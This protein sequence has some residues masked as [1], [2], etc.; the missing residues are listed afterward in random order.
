MGKKYIASEE[1]WKSQV[2]ESPTLGSGWREPY[3]ALHISP[4]NLQKLKMRFSP[5]NLDL[6][7]FPQVI[8]STLVEKSQ[9]LSGLKS[10]SQSY[11]GSLKMPPRVLLSSW[12]TPGCVTSYGNTDDTR[13][14]KSTIFSCHLHV[15]PSRSSLLVTLETN[16]CL[17]EDLR[18]ATCP[19]LSQ[20]RADLLPQT[21]R[22][23]SIAMRNDTTTL[24]H[25]EPHKGPC[26]SFNTSSLQWMACAL[27]CCEKK[28]QCPRILLHLPQML[29]FYPP[30]KFEQ[31][32]LHAFWVNLV[33]SLATRHAW[34]QGYVT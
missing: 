25:W 28:E 4:P 33:A 34:K 32:I 11:V 27:G 16:W 10:Q 31:R 20:S 5:A 21:C 22:Q 18:W 26:S 3:W 23:L 24:H 30:P 13:W 19:S 15:V 29:T 7:V 6:F 9:Y 14:K 2:S 12:G 1:I 17:T 8:K